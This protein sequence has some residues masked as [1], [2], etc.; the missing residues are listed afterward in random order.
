MAVPQIES[1]RFGRIVVDGQVH[2]RD[3]IILPHRVIGG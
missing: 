2:T 1:Y 3:V